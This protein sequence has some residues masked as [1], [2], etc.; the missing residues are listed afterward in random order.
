MEVIMT[1]IL[2]VSWVVLIMVGFFGSIFLL[3]RNGLYDD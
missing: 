1:T 3:K 2:L